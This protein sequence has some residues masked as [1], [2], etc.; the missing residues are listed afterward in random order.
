[1]VWQHTRLNDQAI[2]IC[3]QT[4]QL[5]W[6]TVSTTPKSSA[7]QRTITLD[8]E[9]TTVLT[10]WRAAQTAERLQVGQAWNDSGFVFTHSAGA[11]LYP[12]WVSALFHRLAQ[13][14]GL[15]PIRLHDLR[16][17]AASLSL[18]AGVDVTVVSTEL[19]HAT[20]G[21][22]QDT[23]Q[24]VFPEVAH[25]AAEATAALLPLDRSRKRRV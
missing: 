6:D 19:G 14:A 8:T 1:M 17:G 3:S 9:T 13:Q 25:Q 23:Y 4:V 10:H 22:T 24:H 7:G 2:D 12:A 11:P 18:A 5:G 20:T 16:H 21:F 15:P